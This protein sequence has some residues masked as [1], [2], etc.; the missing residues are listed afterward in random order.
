MED[1]PFCCIHSKHV[2]LTFLR[3]KGHLPAQR[4]PLCIFGHIA[5]SVCHFVQHGTVNLIEISQQHDLGPFS[6]P[7]PLFPA[8]SFWQTGLS[9]ESGYPFSLP[10]VPRETSHLYNFSPPLGFLRFPAFPLE[11][12]GVSGF[13]KLLHKKERYPLCKKEDIFPFFLSRLDKV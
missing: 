2:P 4:A 5:E 8:A 13:S 1:K 3:R 10:E 12:P 6:C 11:N 9:S 7:A